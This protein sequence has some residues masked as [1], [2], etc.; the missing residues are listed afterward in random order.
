DGKTVEPSY[1]FHHDVGRH[2]V[3]FQVV[4]QRMAGPDPF[5]AGLVFRHPMVQVAPGNFP[6]F[7]LGAHDDRELFG[8]MLPAPS[9]IANKRGKEAGEP[10]SLIRSSRFEMATKRLGSYVDTIDRL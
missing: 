5:G 3:F 2:D 9:P 1:R 8:V 7:V 6:H 10:V 4:Q